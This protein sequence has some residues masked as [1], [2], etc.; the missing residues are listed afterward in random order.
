MTRACL[1]RLI[2]VAGVLMSAPC[3]AQSSGAP[4]KI[5]VAFLPGAAP[6]ILG[7]QVAEGLSRMLNQT[8]IVENRSGANG[9]IGSETV[10][11][12]AADGHTLLLAVQSSIVISPHLYK[13]PFNP[14]SDLVAVASLA[15]NQYL[16]AV[17]NAVAATTL[18]EFIELAKVAN[19]PLAYGSSGI[20]SQQ[21]LAME[22][23]IRRA[24]IEGMIHIPYKGASGA[25]AA[26]MAGEVAA[27]F[28]GSAVFE[29]VK[30]GKLRGIAVTGRT[31]SDAL[32]NVPAINETY[33]D[34]EIEVWFGLMARAG[35][36][37]PILDRLATATRSL[38]AEDAF[39][40]RMRSTGSLDVLDLSRSQFSDLIRNDYERYRTII[41][42]LG[43]TGTAN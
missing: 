4:I 13:L 6:D 12:S 32:P 7:R 36:P 19:P 2:A 43:L 23:L 42:Q 26:M 9:N 21:H 41:S 38:L 10:A 31:R 14:V 5:I 17:N 35:T 24:G 1:A 39:V 25:A 8:V 34:Y 28:S 30:A 15:S 29:P 20:G 40:R 27:G 16:L 37:E 11:R 18:H 22:I 33:R 3:F